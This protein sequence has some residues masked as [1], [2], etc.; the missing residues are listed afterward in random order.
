MIDDIAP[1]AEASRVAAAAPTVCVLSLS[2]IADDPRVRRQAEAFHRAG[3]N[4]VGIGLP[5]AK[6]VPPEWP[7]LTRER[8]RP[9][10]PPLD[11]R[12]AKSFLGRLPERLLYLAKRLL[13]AAG[14]LAVR[15]HPSLACRIYWYLSRDIGEVYRCAYRLD[16]AVWLA[17]DWNMLPAA[18]R[19]ARQ[20]G[21]FFGYDS[22]EFAT[23]EYAESRRWRLW[24]RPLV[25]AIER[26]FIRDA[27]VV[28][29][30]SGGI[31]ERLDEIYGLARPSLVVRN[32]PF[33]EE[34]PFRPTG[35]QIRVLYHGIVAKGRGLEEAIDSV[36]EW[37]PQFELTIRGPAAAEYGR[38]LRERIR[39]SG[40]SGRV[41]LAPPVPMLR[42]IQEATAFD[43][44]F[45]ALPGHSRHN[46]F[47][48]PNKLFEYLAAGLAVCVSD[49]PEMARLVAHYRVGVT[50]AA[51]EPTGIA[52]AVNSLDAAAIDGFKRNALAAA[53][54]LCWE[55]EAGR[56][57]EA[58]RAALADAVA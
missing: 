39:R 50:F 48:L 29:A 25:A 23:E 20:K 16:A 30:V 31:A 6:S 37:P 52:A 24:N 56:L 40:S 22:H 14:K 46:R 57:V 42:L 26:R 17:N 55:R 4:V 35:R 9:A 33:Y 47:A 11:R 18:A 15:V 45:F 8:K 58:Y 32:T 53:R 10:R 36:A 7:I 21:G 44:G 41:Q 54:E 2:A 43:I 3:W 28:S 27:V 34:H 5:G 51:G 38:A 1:V 12:A 13:I 49:L 19:L